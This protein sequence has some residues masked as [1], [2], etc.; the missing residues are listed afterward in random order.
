M[1]PRMLGWL[2]GALLVAGAL[3]AA[4]QDARSTTA[5]DDAVVVAVIDGSFSPYHLD[6]RAA[7]MPQHLDADPANDLPLDTPANEWLAGFPDPAGFA[8]FEALRLTLPGNPAANVNTL[9]AG[10]AD[11]WSRFTRSSRGEAHVRWLPG[12]KAIAA[13]DFNGAWRSNNGA[14]GNGTSSVSVGNIYGSCPEC[15]WVPITYGGSGDREAAIDWAMSQPWIDVITNSYGFS[16]VYRDRLYSGSDVEAQRD[17]VSRGQT[18]FFSAGNGQANTFTVPNTT[19]FSSQE[20][21]DWIITVG[22][23]TPFGGNHAYTGSGKSADVGAPGGGYPSG[24]SGNQTINSR[25]NFG[26]TSNATPVMAGLYGRALWLARRA[27]EGPSRTQQDG[28]IAVGAPLGCGAANAGCAL[29]DGVLTGAELRTTLLRSADPRLRQ[30]SPSGV[31]AVPVTSAEYS[32]SA[33]GHGFFLGRLPGDD[34]WLAEVARITDALDGTAPEPEITA[35]LRDWMVVD[36]WCRQ[37]LW[38]AWDGG[39]WASGQALP[40]PEPS[41]PL[42]TAIATTCDGLFP[43]LTPAA[44]DAAGLD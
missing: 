20:G 40:D 15:L 23:V 30:P 19:Y 8:S 33:V 28:A 25:G 29:G 16:A 2:V 13:L 6:Y 9:A 24:Y 21:P 43:P 38:G 22:G 39:Y 27:L 26:G 14:H 18:I 7:G 36:S 17:A 3:P 44:E 37:Q 35:D 5:G 42:R 41:F 31:A 11:E 32:Y 12:T 10:D 4:A 34:H 1:G